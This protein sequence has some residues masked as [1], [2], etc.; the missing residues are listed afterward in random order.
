MIALASWSRRNERGAG[1]SEILNEHRAY[2][3]DATRLA[4][5]RAAVERTL[6]PGDVV[7]DLGCGF[8]VLGLL[9]LQAG[10]A[11]V[12]GVD[13]TRAL[14]IARETFRRAGLGE[15]YICVSGLASQIEL[16]ERVDVAICDHFGA[17]GFDYGAIDLLR[18]A[19]ERFLKPGGRL[20][21]SRL[22]LHIAAARS[23]PCRETVGAWRSPAVPEEYRWL[24]NY[25]A[26]A[27]LAATLR[28]DDLLSDA[29]ALG[30]IDL[31]A[32]SGETLAFEAE[33][34]VQRDGVVDG[35]A[36]WFDCE[37][38]DGVSMTN[39]P[40][41]ATAIR[42]EQAFLPIGEPL[43]VI[44]GET[45]KATMTARPEDSIIAWTLEAPAR[46]RR[47]AHSNWKSVILSR[48]DLDLSRLDAPARLTPE[49][50]ARRIILNY[51]DG[52]RTKSEIE[53]A[54]LRDH[55]R[56]FPSRA[57]ISRFVGAV[58]RRDAQ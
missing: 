37:L 56:L 29:A 26:N 22:S 46:G 19:R 18:D 38:A 3:A 4:C 20:I 54:A 45:L 43:P 5:F 13:S 58:L 35:L 47:F 28:P 6:R 25:E 57:E 21:P 2:I 17:F 24:C 1:V 12:Y 42:R 8:G 10:A 33:L 55:P 31:G 44:A 32:H 16:P 9:C 53:A 49:G 40:L 51:C 14:E 50:E 23:S 36:G 30:S 52:E 34:R 7:A 48:R 11:R 39:S 27:V 15:R 41:A